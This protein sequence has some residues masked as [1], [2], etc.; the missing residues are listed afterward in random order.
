MASTRSDH[1]VSVLLQ[2][3]VWVVIKVQHWYGIKLSRCTARFWHIIWKHQV[4]LWMENT[5]ELSP[6]VTCVIFTISSK[7]ASMKLHKPVVDMIAVQWGK[8]EIII[9]DHQT[10]SFAQ[11]VKLSLVITFWNIY[12]YWNDIH[13]WRCYVHLPGF[14]QWRGWWHSCGRWV[15]TNTPRHS[16]KPHIPPAR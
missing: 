7:I 2:N 13:T 15:E 6:M 4:D 12:I 11:A 3:D 9:Q 14:A 10:I 1:H 5:M 8:A 16:K